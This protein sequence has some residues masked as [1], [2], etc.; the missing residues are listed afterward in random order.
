[1]A[2]TRDGE[3]AERLRGVQN[4]FLAP[5]MG[6]RLRLGAQYGLYSRF[7]TSRRY[8]LAQDVLHAVSRFGLFIGSSSEDELVG[9]RPR[10]REWLMSNA[11]QRAGQ[12][13]IPT[14]ADRSAHAHVLAEGYERQLRSAGFVTPER[15]PDAPLLRYPTFVANKNSLLAAARAER[16]ELGSW[17]ESP[18]HPIGLELHGRYG[19][20]PGQ[21]ANAEWAAQRIVN[22]P[23]HG[24]VTPEEA[25]RIARFFVTHAVQPPQV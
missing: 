1:M 21:C 5:P 24:G 3:V 22:L 17:F 15:L 9:E 12:R 19:Y 4:A 8:W 7:F 25:A 11:Q 13:M 16:V 6:A 2:V 20:V 14:V 10:D 18:L 23:L